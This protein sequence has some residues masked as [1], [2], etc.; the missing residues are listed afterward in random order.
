[1]K[2]LNSV[3][4]KMLGASADCCVSLDIPQAIVDRK[5]I[6]ILHD[7]NPYLNSRPLIIY[8]HSSPGFD[9]GG[10]AVAISLFF[11]ILS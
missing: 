9:E 11:F 2:I 5:G 7:L 3:F 8:F 1:M 10:G 4:W 6:R